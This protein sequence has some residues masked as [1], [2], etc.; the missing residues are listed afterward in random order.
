MCIRDRIFADLKNVF[1]KSDTLLTDL[2]NLTK[3]TMN[4]QNNVGKLLYDEDVIKDLKQTLKQVNDLTSI[5]IEQLKNDGIN[6]DA[7]IF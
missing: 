6:V 1:Q 2:N 7:N 4:Q 5:L 3:E